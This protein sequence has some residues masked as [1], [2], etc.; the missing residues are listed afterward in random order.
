[1]RAKKILG[2]QHRKVWLS[3]LIQ[4]DQQLGP[5][6]KNLLA[7]DL[8][9]QAKKLRGPLNQAIQRRHE[10]CCAGCTWT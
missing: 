7:A 4:A 6:G 2:D 9:Q 8:I 1:M 3:Q 10:C 5:Y